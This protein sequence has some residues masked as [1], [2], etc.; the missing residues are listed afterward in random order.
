M[1][2]VIEKVKSCKEQAKA[3]E[4]IGFGGILHI[5]LQ[6]MN[7]DLYFWLVKNFN[8]VG[9]LLSIGDGRDAI[10]IEEYDVYDV[11]CLPRNPNMDVVLTPRQR[12]PD[13]ADKQIVDRW[14]SKYPLGGE[15]ASSAVVSC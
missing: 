1:T 9:Y 12:L 5:K 11:F 13:S 7:R 10:Q 4:E 6:E 2:E 3:V 8:G 14:F 15:A